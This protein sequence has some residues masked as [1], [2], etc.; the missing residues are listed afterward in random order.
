VFDEIDSLVAD[1]VSEIV[2]AS[3]FPRVHISSAERTGAAIF[4]KELDFARTR[5][6]KVLREAGNKA[7]KQPFETLIRE[8][9]GINTGYAL[10]VED[11]VDFARRLEN[12]DREES[13]LSKKHPE[14][15]DA[16]NSIIGGAYKVDKNTGLF[17][18]P[19][20]GKK[21]HFTMN[22]SS[23]CVRAL[24]DMCFY[25]RG[26]AKPGDLFMI[27]EPELNLHPKN[28]R[29]LARLIVRLVNA[30]VKVFITTHSDYL[31]KEFNTLIML[32]QKTEH[33]R[34]I[35]MKYKYDDTELLDHTRVRLYVAGT[36]SKRVTGSSNAS[37]IN[38]LIP[39]K[40][41]SLYGI[42]AE[43]FDDTIDMMNSIQE[44]ILY[45]GAL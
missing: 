14:I 11:N 28:Q 4:R 44:D 38:T 30:G 36:K 29:T 22:E 45:G 41:G 40:I 7:S 9:R 15:L 24:V 12:I 35:Q 23:S 20:E 26:R 42:E 37:K 2:F 5:M 39:A 32:N 27:D 25:L 31:I 10:P 33:T 18:Q 8:L 16:F 6:L 43:T 3:K 34:K 1:A 17:F 13:E 21:Q 19:K